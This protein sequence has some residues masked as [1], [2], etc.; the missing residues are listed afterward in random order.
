MTRPERGSEKKLTDAGTPPWGVANTEAAGVAGTDEGD[1][2]CAACTEA[3]A[4]E[5]ATGSAEVVV[6]AEARM[7][8]AWAVKAM[9]KARAKAHPC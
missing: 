8:K 9:E 2:R 7:E 3:T 4:A 1:E 6:A 5:V